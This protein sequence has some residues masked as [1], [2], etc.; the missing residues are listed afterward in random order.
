MELRD[1][2]QCQDLRLV[3]QGCSPEAVQEVRELLMRPVSQLAAL[4]I[5]TISD[6][7]ALCPDR[8]R[9]VSALPI[10]S[11]FQRC[12]L[13]EQQVEEFEFDSKATR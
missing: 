10:P 12:I 4:C 3:R 11:M 2:R 1:L 13:F 8:E 5:Q 9:K 7:I 6:S